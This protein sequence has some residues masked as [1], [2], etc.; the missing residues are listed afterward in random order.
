MSFDSKKYVDP[1]RSLDDLV[2]I[3]NYYYPNKLKNNRMVCPFHDDKNPSFY[4]NENHL[5]HSF[6]KCFGCGE[7]GDI[8]T[9]IRKKEN[10]NFVLALKK[11]YKILGRNLEL[12][13]SPE[14][15]KSEIFNRNYNH[16]NSTLMIPKSKNITNNKQATIDYLNM[17]IKEA[18]EKGLDYLV[19]DYEQMKFKEESINYHIN[20]PFVDCDQNVLKVWE[21]LEC[22]LKANNI[23]VYY[24]EISKSI[25]LDGLPSSNLNDCVLDI[26]SLCY[27]Y[28]L[29][30]GLK[31]IVE[32]ISKIGMDNPQNPVRKYLEDC[33]KIY[34]FKNDN[35]DK[36]CDCIITEKNFNERLKR[37]LITKW[38]INT[39]RIV[40]NTEG[41]MNVEGVL[42][43]QG[44]QG[45][46]K[47]RFI[48]KIIPLYV[49]TGIDLDPSD[50]DKINQCIKY[51]V[52]E[53][54]E[55]DST[56]KKDL[57]KLKAFLTEQEDEYRKPYAAFPV[58]YPRMTS[59][60]AT[61]N[62]G[63]FLKDET[64]NRRYWVI[65]VEKIDFEK[66][67]EIDINQL[68][69][70]VMHL[71]CSNKYPHYLTKEEMRMLTESNDE[72][73]PI[74]NVAIMV[75]G[76]F[77]WKSPKETWGWMSSSDIAR[78]FNLKSTKGL[79]G[80]MEFYGGTYYKKGG[81][82]GYICPQLIRIW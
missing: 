82:R 22:L 34:D 41:N 70:E 56:L 33:E 68:W 80:A 36:L 55:L 64:G 47:T 61:V 24:N 42:T 74:G 79:K 32:F 51:W 49:K 7:G 2:T 18:K 48:R 57:A 69:G 77:N 65:P 1:I 5:G 30:L 52:C 21:N 37:I 63:D 11:A 19:A 28:G 14:I 66:L 67:D 31:Q 27:K 78:T 35:I 8:I 53:L 26:H 81:I 6:Y 46:G 62:Q 60:Y 15:F 73:T 45:L 25:E 12:P 3:I 40:Y 44:S 13:I 58:K 9:F 54:G 50:K 71:L 23:E 43:L 4:I 72:F 38:L 59:F 17:K 20:F 10:I 16:N 39:A 76:G 75:E 29:K